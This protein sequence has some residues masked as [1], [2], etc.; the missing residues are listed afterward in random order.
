MRVT[1]LNAYYSLVV[2]KGLF[3]KRHVSM[4]FTTEEIICSIESTH[5]AN[6]QA[7]NMVVQW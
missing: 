4:N 6:S 1:N 2:S 7:C 5:T 3:S